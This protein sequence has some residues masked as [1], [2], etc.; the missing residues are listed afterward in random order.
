MSTSYEATP[1]PVTYGDGSP[2]AALAAEDV[3]RANWTPT[4]QYRSGG[5]VDSSYS[6]TNAALTAALKIRK[7]GR[8]MPRLY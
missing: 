7:A 1:G 6:P 3:R 5:Y 8:L 2:A 4:N